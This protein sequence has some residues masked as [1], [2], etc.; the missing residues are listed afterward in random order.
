[1]RRTESFLRFYCA[2][3]AAVASA[4]AQTWTPTMAPTNLWNSICSSADGS[5]FAAV[6]GSGCFVST[7]SE[8]DWESNSLPSPN[9]LSV[10]A[11]SADGM[12][13][14][15]ARDNTPSVV[16]VSTNGGSNWTSPTNYSDQFWPAIACSKDFKIQVLTEDGPG[17]L[18][19]TNSG[20]T[21]YSLAQ[22]PNN[23]SQSAYAALSADGR[24]LVVAVNGKC[25]CS[26]TNFGGNWATNHLAEPWAGIAASADGTK[27]VAAPYG[28]NIYTSTDS[29]VTWVPQTNSPNLLWWSVAS[30]ADGTKLAAVS[31]RAASSGQ[32]YTSADSGMSWTSNNAPNLAWVSVASSADGNT[33]V[34]AVYNGG[35]W[36]LQTTPTPHLNLAPA[37]TNIALSWIIPSTNFAVQKSPDLISWA[38]VTNAPVL[39][40]TNLQDQISLSPSNRSGFYRLATP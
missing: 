19:S 26:T 7:N 18:A 37:G 9:S 1:M 2:W 23:G 5:R 8:G 12:K 25:I 22:L 3:L 15:G 29:G 38:V 34:A 21:W 10:I 17:I 24:C 40:L 35:I 39:N 14:V 30:S 31:G 13:L 11:A 16:E 28:G 4:S 27:V 20:A 6:G 33:L 32:I 36:T